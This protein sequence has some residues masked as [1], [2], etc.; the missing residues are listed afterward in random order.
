MLSCFPGIPILIWSGAKSKKNELWGVFARHT[1]VAVSTV[2]LQWGKYIYIYMN[3]HK[4]ETS[5]QHLKETLN[6][7]HSNPTWTKLKPLVR[8]PYDPDLSS[9]EWSQVPDSFR[10]NYLIMHSI[11]IIEKIRDNIKKL[12]AIKFSLRVLISILEFNSRAFK[13]IK[14]EPNAFSSMNHQYVP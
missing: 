7:Q 12:I 14:E 10:I 2:H 9:L 13:W 8:E 6:R 1:M 5:V 4:V 11:S 3:L